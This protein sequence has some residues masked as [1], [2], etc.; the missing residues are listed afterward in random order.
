M[1]MKTAQKADVCW[2]QAG[3]ALFFA[4]I[5]ASAYGTIAFADTAAA[6]S[7]ATT[8]SQGSTQDTTTTTTQEAA[9]AQPAASE[10]GA[11]PE[12]QDKNAPSTTTLKGNVRT[13]ELSLERLRDIGLDMKQMLRA[14][15]NLY[16][17]VTIRPVNIISEPEL[18]GNSVIYIPVGFQSAGPPQPP[19]KERVNLA[20]SQMRPIILVLKQDVDDFLEGRSTLEISEK[21][22]QDLTPLFDKWVNHVNNISDSLKRLNQ[23]TPGPK[24]D[25]ETIA[26]ATQSIHTNIKQ[27]D[28][29]RRNIYRYVQK[30]GRQSKKA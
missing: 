9:Q 16:D 18:I 10:A 24:Y 5:V 30:E 11:Q 12:N 7:T 25:N 29:V 20:M 27:L 17:E 4:T 28:K 14:S 1:V 2:L 13:L 3:L 21:Q 19:R 22:R 15:S 6:T 23:L 8:E 26:S